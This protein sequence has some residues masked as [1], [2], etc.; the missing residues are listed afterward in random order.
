MKSL[1]RKLVMHTAE[2]M[3]FVNITAQVEKAVAEAGVAE[4]LCL[5]NFGHAGPRRGQQN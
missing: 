3:A 4:G 5:V 2:R 1:T